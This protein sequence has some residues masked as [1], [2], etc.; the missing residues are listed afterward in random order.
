[1]RV[2]TFSVA[3]IP[4]FFGLGFAAHAE[5]SGG[6]GRGWASGKGNGEYQMRAGEQSCVIDYPAFIDDAKGTRT[7]ATELALTRAP[8]AGKIGVSP[9]GIV[10]M[11]PAGFA[12]QDRFCIRNTTPQV[13]GKTLSGC[14]TVTVR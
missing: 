11:P 12:G 3:I 6:L 8:A 9:Q 4:L 13:R 1:M 7:P 10:Y 5:C 2:S 14:V